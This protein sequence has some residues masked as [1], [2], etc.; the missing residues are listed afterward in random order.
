MV[1]VALLVVDWVGLGR[2]AW[3]VG[4]VQFC[5][6]M[7]AVCTEGWGV[8][9]ALQEG[10]VVYILQGEGERGGYALQGG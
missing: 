1:H 6:E 9:H 5:R 10:R 7:G 2:N 3:L 8:I 4:S